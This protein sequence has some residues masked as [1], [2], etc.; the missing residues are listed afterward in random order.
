MRGARLKFAKRLPGIAADSG[1]APENTDGR[2]PYHAPRRRSATRRWLK[3]RIAPAQNRETARPEDLVIVFIAS[4]VLP[5]EPRAAGMSYPKL[6]A[7]APRPAKLCAAAKILPASG[8]K[9]AEM[10]AV[11]GAHP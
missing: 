1:P 7:I 4:F 9:K 11:R 5:A 8:R 3:L 2:P 10:K 6:C